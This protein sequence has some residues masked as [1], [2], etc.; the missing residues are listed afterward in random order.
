MVIFKIEPVGSKSPAL[1]SND[2]RKSW[3]DR[4]QTHAIALLCPAQAFPVP[5]FRLNIV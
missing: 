3:I 1:A 5:A 4:Q 2:Q